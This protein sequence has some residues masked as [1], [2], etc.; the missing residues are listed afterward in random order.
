MYNKQVFKTWIMI[1]QVGISMMT[2]IF[3]LLVISVVLKNKFN[4]D[5]VLLSI[6]IGVIVGF[7]NTYILLKQFLKDDSKT[8]ESELLK[9]H[10]E[11][12]SSYKFN[13]D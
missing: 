12:I 13:I 6:I 9:K 10:K 4:I 5:L 11:N 8:K 2:P 3:L 1:L 7:R